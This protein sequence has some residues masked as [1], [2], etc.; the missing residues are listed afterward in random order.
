MQWTRWQK[1]LGNNSN[2]PRPYSPILQGQTMV[3]LARPMQDQPPSGMQPPQTYLWLTCPKIL[4]RKK[5]TC[6]T[7]PQ[8]SWLGQHWGS[9]DN[10]DN[11][12]KPVDLKF[13][14]RFLRHWKKMKQTHQSDSAACPQC[15]FENFSPVVSLEFPSAQRA[16]GLP[17]KFEVADVKWV[18]LLREIDFS[19]SAKAVQSWLFRA[20]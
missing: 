18:M 8:D 15:H 4:E 12:T 17:W 10:N 1:T 16:I 5:Q 19:R 11:L 3:T 2:Q 14:H 20:S 9:D 7:G 13:C 6:T